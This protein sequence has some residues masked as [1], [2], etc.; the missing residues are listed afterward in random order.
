MSDYNPN[1]VGS[2]HGCLDFLLSTMHLLLTILGYRRGGQKMQL[3]AL[4]N[5]KFNVFF[6]KKNSAIFY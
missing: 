3:T 6:K 5:P 1:H 2:S 4:A